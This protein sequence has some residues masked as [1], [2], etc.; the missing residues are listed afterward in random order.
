MNPAALLSPKLWVALAFAG[1]L[2]LAGWFYVGMQHAETA[3]AQNKQA[4]AETLTKIANLTTAALQEALATTKARDE[5]LAKID[6]LATEGKDRE[7]QQNEA[8]RS[9]VRAGTQ[10]LR[11]AAVCPAS[12][13]TGDVPQASSAGGLGPASTVELAPAAGQDVLN[14]RAGIIADQAALEYLQ[15]YA[16]EVCGK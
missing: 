16:T 10:R 5:A 8:I 3:L 1:V 14:I 9:A 15:Q 11:I 13:S 7:L 2:A 4:N 6:K 12:G